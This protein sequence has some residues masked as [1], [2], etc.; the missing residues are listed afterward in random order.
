MLG[1]RLY[2]NGSGKNP[3]MGSCDCGNGMSD[4]INSNNLL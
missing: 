2:S 3:V 4:P 1:Y